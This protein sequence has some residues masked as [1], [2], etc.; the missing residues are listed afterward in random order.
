[1]LKTFSPND[2]GNDYICSDIHGHFSLLEAE[3]SLISFD[4]NKDRLFC[5]GDLI[6]RG[7]ESDLALTG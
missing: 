7:D 5:V 2:V 6:D 3:L 4:K 1:M